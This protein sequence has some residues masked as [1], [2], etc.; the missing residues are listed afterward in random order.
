MWWLSR[1]APHERNGLDLGAVAE[2]VDC[3]L[4]PVDNVEDA[5]W[6]SRLC[7]ELCDHHRRRRHLFRGLEDKGVAGAD[8]DWEHPEGNHGREVEGRNARD[9]AKRLLHGDGVHVPA[10]CLHGLA[11]HECGHANGMLHHLDAA[12]HIPVGVWLRLAVLLD[13]GPR[14]LVLVLVQERVELH[15]DAGSLLDGDLAPP[16]L[17]FGGIGDNR[18]HLRLRRAWHLHDELLSGRV[19]HVQG[20]RGRR[21]H[22]LATIV[23][24]KDVCHALGGIRLRGGCLLQFV[25]APRSLLQ[26]GNTGFPRKR[27]EVS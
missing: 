9:D 6:E 21:C 20:L 18:L 15:Q 23:Q 25:A 7:G 26:P 11:H 4:A 10:N 1:T 22:L 24:G 14:N 8:C 2:K 13:D 17:R 16:F 12:K 19:E 5:I 3:V 27:G